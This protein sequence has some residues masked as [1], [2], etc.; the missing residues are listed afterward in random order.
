MYDFKITNII[1]QG[2]LF[3]LK[4]GL[5]SL[6]NGEFRNIHVCY[7]YNNCTGIRNDDPLIQNTEFGLTIGAGSKFD[8]DKVIIDNM[9]GDVGFYVV[10][11]FNS[12]I[13][14]LQIP[15]LETDFSI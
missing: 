10:Q 3:K 1:S 12:L 6:N 14:L 15:I 4:N 2:V 9:N 7:K 11:I 8:M 13:R 5:V